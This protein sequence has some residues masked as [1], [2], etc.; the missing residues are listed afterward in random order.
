MLPVGRVDEHE[1]LRCDQ[2][3]L[4]ETHPMD[5]SQ[6]ITGDRLKGSTI[7]IQFQLR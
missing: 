3:T 5:N 2:E 6:R 7:L 4:E 1:E